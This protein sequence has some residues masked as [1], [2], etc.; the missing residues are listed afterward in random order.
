MHSVSLKHVL[1][2]DGFEDMLTA[3]RKHATQKTSTEPAMPGRLSPQQIGN[4]KDDG[5]LLFKQPVLAQPKFD[6]LKAHFEHKLEMWDEKIDGT[7]EHMDVPH[8]RD[9]KLFEWLLADE[10]LDVV[11]SLIGPDIALWSSHFI[12]K[13]AG[14][15][16]RV[17]WHEDSA[18]W[19]SVLDPMEVVTVWLAIDPSTPTNGCMRIIPRTHN[20]GYSQYA[21]VSD[22]QKQVFGSEIKAGQFDE[23]TAV[24]CTL[25]PN[26]CSIHHAKL[27]HGSNPN[28]SAFRRCGYTMRY[29]PATSKFRPDPTRNAFQIYLARGKDRAG[30]SYG[31]P[32]K[33]NQRWIDATDESRRLAKQLA[34]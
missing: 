14:R 21:P 7:P 9:V 5:Y 32:T 24:D 15:G 11:E 34:G 29:V 13:P 33:V 22:A 1:L 27:I 2:C 4:F 30:N 20:N 17:P 26:E 28:T 25:D 8:F 12:C 18:Y 6:A 10:V 23:N 16:K 31:D 3:Y 19:G